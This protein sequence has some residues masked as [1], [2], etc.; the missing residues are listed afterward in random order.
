VAVRRQSQAHTGRL[1]DAAD[2]YNAVLEGFALPDF[3][4]YE[5]HLALGQVRRCHGGGGEGRGGG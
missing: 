2:S 4:A 5:V 3:E 1:D